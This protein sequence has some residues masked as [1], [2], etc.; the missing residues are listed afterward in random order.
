MQIEWLCFVYLSI[1]K[2]N[3]HH[4]QILNILRRQLNW[5]ATPA[6]I[7]HKLEL[8]LPLDEPVISE[9]AVCEEIDYLLMARLIAG[10]DVEGYKLSN[11]WLRLP[12]EI[13]AEWLCYGSPLRERP[14][15]E[16]P[17]EIHRRWTNPY[18]W[19]SN[20]WFS[21]EFAVCQDVGDGDIVSII[22]SGL[23]QAAK[24]F[25]AQSIRDRVSA[26]L[27]R[28]YLTPEGLAAWRESC[29]DFNIG[30]LANTYSESL[31][32]LL[33]EVGLK[34]LEYLSTAGDS[35]WQHDNILGKPPE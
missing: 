22:I 19:E 1:S 20:S 35:S 27:T 26:A 31:E 30:D 32:A 7:R 21:F 3:M 23:S 6:G 11:H 10:N 8:D 34:D 4:S 5:A 13:Q 29:A 18:G 2:V 17:A 33:Q 14:E 12:E 24:V 9:A 28:W 25:E 15:L 16:N